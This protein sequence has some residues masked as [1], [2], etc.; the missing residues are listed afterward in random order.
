MFYYI[1]LDSP[2]LFGFT[3]DAVAV[4]MLKNVKTKQKKAGS[5][6]QFPAPISTRPQCSPPPHKRVKFILLNF[7]F[8]KAPDQKS[9][10]VTFHIEQLYTLP[11]YLTNQ[12][13]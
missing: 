7:I 12:I 3:L 13:V 4:I 5:D 8:Y 2:S 11:Y 10:K 1:F 6:A 9:F